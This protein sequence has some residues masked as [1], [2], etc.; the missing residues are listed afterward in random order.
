[1]SIEEL[2]ARHRSPDRGEKEAAEDDGSEGREEEHGE[3]HAQG[4]LR[5]LGVGRDD[6]QR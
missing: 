6:E 5:P 3:H 2:V 1:M 4:A